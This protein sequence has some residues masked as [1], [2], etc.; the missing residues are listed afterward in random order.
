MMARKA[1]AFCS[2]H[3][4]VLE[5]VWAVCYEWEGRDGRDYKGDF[6]IKA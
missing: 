5:M 2:V 3:V 6:V 1:V 4:C